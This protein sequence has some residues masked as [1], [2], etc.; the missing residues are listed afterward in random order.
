M[1]CLHWLPAFRNPPYICSSANRPCHML[2]IELPPPPRCQCKG[3]RQDKRRADGRT[4]VYL[5]DLCVIE[6]DGGGGRWPFSL[7]TARY[8]FL[9]ACSPLLFPTSAYVRCNKERRAM[10]AAAT[11]GR[12][13]MRTSRLFTFV[14]GFWRKTQDRLCNPLGRRL[15]HTNW[16]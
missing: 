3:S 9:H 5:R 2:E 8:L 12:G 13:S 14:R 10:A 4:Q 11:N 1:A 16:I 6:R 7:A 15:V